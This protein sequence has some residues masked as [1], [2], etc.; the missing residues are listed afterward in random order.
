MVATRVLRSGALTA[1]FAPAFGMICSSLLHRGEELLGQRKGLEEYARGGSTMGIP[2]LHPWANRLGGFEY[3]FAGVA[4]TIDPGDVRLEEHGLPVHGIPAAVRGWETVEATDV[5]LVAGRD[6]RGLAAFPFDHRI[7]VAAEL[8]DSRL[9]ITT[10]LTALGDRP[11]PIC[12]GH[13]PY[14]QLPGVARADWQ[15]TAPVRERLL[16][17]ERLLPTGEREPAGDLDGPLGDRTFDDA[18]TLRPGAFGLAG[19]GRRVEVAFG[20]G[21]RLAQIFAPG[22]LDVVCFE[23]MTAPA[24]ALRHAP[25]AVAPGES[26]RAGFSIS[27]R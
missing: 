10:T 24:D 14:L 9:A 21:Y 11:V 13:H 27:V 22:D 12:F 23:P 19:G 4:V 3:G 20:R 6:V 17:D 18:F 8:D 26:F 7:Q 16:L 1:T 25:A 15:I 2:L 5:R